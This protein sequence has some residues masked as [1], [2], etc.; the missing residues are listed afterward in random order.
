MPDFVCTVLQD[1]AP[2]CEAR[3]DVRHT[4]RGYLRGWQGTVLSTDPPN[5]IWE[6]GEYTFRLADGSE[7]VALINRVR[8]GTRGTSVSFIG[9][10]GFGPGVAPE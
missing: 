6:P 3:I 10:N 9:A 2:L 4:R 1:G 8:M 7:H 5:A